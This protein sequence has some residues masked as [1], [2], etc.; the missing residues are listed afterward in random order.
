[1]ARPRTREA[2]PAPPNGFIASAVNLP[3]VTPKVA[4]QSQQWQADGLAYLDTV[5]ELRFVANW[6]GNVMSRAVLV[7]GHRVEGFIEPVYTGPAADVL[8][9]YFGGPQGQSDM[10]S[11][12][13]V[14]LTVPGEVYHVALNGGE[15]WH[16]LATGR[17]KQQGQASKAAVTADLG[18][19]VR[20]PLTASDL[21]L[22]VWTP[23]P[24]QPLLADSPV[25]SNLSTLSEIQA[26]NQHVQ[27]QLTS[28]LAGAGVLF[29]PSEITFPVPPDA[30]PA[31]S[32]AD[33]FTAVLGEAMTTPIRDRGN[34]SA[35]VPIVVTAPG[36]TLDK[37]QHLT[38][39][40]ELDA[41]AIAM[42]EAAVKKLAIG[43]DAPP[44]VLLGVG[45]STSH[46][47]GWLVSEE[48]I[49]SHLEPRLG[50]VVHAI[51]DAYFRPALEGVV[52]DPENWYVLAD[53][54]QIRL[55]PNRS[56]EAIE[57]YD[58]G[59]LSGDAVRR[60][61]GFDPSDAPKPNE[62]M[63]WLTRRIA[64]G[65][66][67]PEQTQAAL[68]LLGIDLGDLATTQSNA[69]LPDNLRPRR[70]L[71]NH[72]NQGPPSLPDAEQRRD[73][74]G[75][76]VLETPVTPL[77]AACE[78]QVF[79]ALERA[80]NRLSDKRSKGDPLLAVPSHE[81]HIH[82]SGNPDHLLAG[83]WD[84]VPS[85]LNGLTE[86]TDEIVLLLDFYVRGLLTT[87]RPHSRSALRLLIAQGEGIW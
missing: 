80:G 2:Q 12:T 25:R 9:A 28:R 36:E 22:R 17:V 8:T 78:A 62:R 42:R 54:A 63:E 47:G 82:A 83:A 53:T 73:Q 41:T 3:A 71:D 31:A 59:E 50:V 10:L 60:E 24:V 16:V 81:R 21:A 34:A 86:R 45:E 37:V 79:R 57:L 43:M 84:A 26:L 87:N 55:R 30:D 18:D 4:G 56:R 19:G 72:P 69:G 77:A 20:R 64:S 5:A 74:R 65:S 39:W 70:S 52:P 33:V 29:M 23:H 6:V 66:T 13:G 51:T 48:A 27:A 11:K 68:R 61:T 15:S 49:K 44:E 14:H 58:R 76:K 67:S 7:P 1:M 75:R 38:F 32:Q 35:V 40:T 46:W 85:M